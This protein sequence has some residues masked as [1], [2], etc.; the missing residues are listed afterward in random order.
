MANVSINKNI[1]SNQQ[2]N[3]SNKIVANEYVIAIGASTGGTE[4]IF[5]IIH[6]FPKDMPG[7]IIV[8]HMPPVFTR[9]YAQRLNASCKM[10]VK[11]AESGD[12]IIDGTK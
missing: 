6:A 9:M 12:K 8:Q 11:E 4:A 3:V 5:E 7:I 10:E 1:V 2:I